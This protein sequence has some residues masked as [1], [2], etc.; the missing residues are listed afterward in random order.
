M[1]EGKALGGV[2][3]N[4]FFDVFDVDGV[5]SVE[6]E[7]FEGFAFHYQEKGPFGLGENFFS[8][9]HAEDAVNFEEAKAGFAHDPLKPRLIYLGLKF[10]EHEVVDHGRLAA[11]RS[12]QSRA[13]FF[14]A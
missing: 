4:D 11:G 3:L 5:I 6:A 9:T 7:F 2:G 13:P 10:E 8:A 1:V 12:S 14:T